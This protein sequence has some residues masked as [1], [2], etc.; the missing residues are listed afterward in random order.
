MRISTGRAASRPSDRQPTAMQVQRRSPGGELQS[1]KLPRRP[2]SRRLRCEVRAH[3]EVLSCAPP[4]GTR[5]WGVFALADSQSSCC[6]CCSST[7]S[8]ATRRAAVRSHQAAMVRHPGVLCAQQETLC[9]MSR[10]P[11]NA[12]AER[13][14]DC[15]LVNRKAMHLS[16]ST[17]VV[18]VARRTS[19]SRV[20]NRRTR[21]APL[22]RSQPR[23][24]SFLCSSQRP[25]AVKLPV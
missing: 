25:P 12:E 23:S 9:H 8:A 14:Q 10:C 13:F 5:A 16:M 4:C 11:R 1:P 15:S 19:S 17:A 18:A 3:L 24:E 22:P 6:V 2:S 7:C 21:R 20:R